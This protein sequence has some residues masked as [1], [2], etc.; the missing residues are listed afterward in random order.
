MGIRL[1]DD[2]QKVIEAN[3]LKF[4]ETR[5]RIQAQRGGQNGTNAIAPT[6]PMSPWR[7]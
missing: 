1:P 6:I 2:K 3:R 4:E 5:K 7:S